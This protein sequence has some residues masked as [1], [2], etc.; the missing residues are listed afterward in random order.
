LGGDVWFDPERPRFHRDSYGYWPS[1][2]P[3]QALVACRGPCWEYDWVVDLDVQ[4]FCELL[5]LLAVP[6]FYSKASCS[7]MFHLERLRSRDWLAALRHERL[8][9]DASFA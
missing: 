2:S 9:Q 4:Q 6:G 7:A 5:R 8:R 3:L 1:K